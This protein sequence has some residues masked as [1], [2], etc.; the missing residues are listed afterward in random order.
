MKRK[1]TAFL[2]TMGFLAAAGGPARAAAPIGS[3]EE[4]ATYFRTQV[5]KVDTYAEKAP[6]VSSGFPFPLQDINIDLAPMV[7]FGISSVLQLSIAPE[8][9]FVLVPDQPENTE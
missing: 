8:I 5:K 9:D 4:L 6:P 1:R 3:V 2:Y 7:S